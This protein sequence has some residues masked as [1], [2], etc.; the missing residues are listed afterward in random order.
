MSVEELIFCFVLFVFVFS[1][2]FLFV[3]LFLVFFLFQIKE[4]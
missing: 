1:C 3:C 4:S 2:L